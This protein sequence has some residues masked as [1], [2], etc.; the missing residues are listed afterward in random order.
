MMK[1]AS[2][3][4]NS[5]MLHLMEA[6]EPTQINILTAMIHFSGKTQ[7]QT[8]QQNFIMKEI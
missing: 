3:T 1:S 8:A 6:W 4:I 7:P 2:F 5:V